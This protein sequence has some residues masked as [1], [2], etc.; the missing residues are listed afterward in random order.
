MACPIVAI[1]A[2]AGGLEAIA[3]LL[4]ASPPDDGMTYV[5]IQHLDPAHKSLLADILEKKTAIPVQTIHDGM[6]V[7]PGRVYVMPQNVSLTLNDSRFRL[8]ARGSGRHHPIDDF[9]LSLAEVRAEAAIGV[10]LSGADADGTLGMQAIKQR[11][12]ITFAQTPESAR[13]GGMPRSAIES[14]CVD[15]VLRPREIAH[16]LTHLV[17]HPYLARPSG[18]PDDASAASEEALLRRIFR[19]LRAVH[20]VD[21]SHYKRSTLRRRIARRMALHKVEELTDYVAILEND[22]EEAAALYQDFLIRVTGFFRDPESFDGLRERV[23]PDVREGRSLKDPIRIWVPGCATGEEVYSI[24]MVLMEYLGE[25]HSAIG[26]QIFATDVSEAAIEKARAALY[27]DVVAQELSA[28]RLKRFFVKEDHRYRV[29]KSLRDLCIFARQDVT[30]DP[31]FSRLDLVSC[32]N[33]LIYLDAAAQRRVMQIFHYALR[34]NGFL[35]LGPSESVGTARDFFELKDK[36]RRIYKRKVLAAGAGLE[37]V[38]TRPPRYDRPQGQLA[39]AEASSFL[40]VDS[41]Q[42]E[43]DLLLLARF[44]PASLLVD[45]ALNILQVRGE[46]GRYLELAS[47]Q[48]SLNLHRVAR[49]ELLVEIVPAIQ[50]ARENGTAAR[51][52]GLS[53]SELR[54]ITIEVIPLQRL[55]TERC[56][57]ILFDDGSRSLLARRSKVSVTAALPESEKDRRLE[58]LEREIGAMRDY[59]QASTEEHEAVKEEL[60]SAHEEVLSANEEFQSTN[61]ELETAKE[62]LQS[63]NE[64]L[65][66]TNDELRNRNRELSVLNTEVHTARETSERA[67]SYAEAIINAVRDPLIVLDGNLKVLRAN[68]AF[69]TNFKVRS[70]DIEGRFLS[71]IDD[72][73]WNVPE[74]IERLREVLTC[75]TIIGNFHVRYNLPNTLLPQTLRVNARKIP[76][77]GERAEL[78]LMAVEDADAEQLREAMQRKDEFLAML[79]HELRNPLT[80]IAHAIHL[81]RHGGA[82]TSPEKAYDLIERQTARLVR[83]VDQLLDVA[84]ISRGHIDLKR[85]TVDLANVV[86]NAADAIQTRLEERQ[87]TL[88][89]MLP[90]GPV[91]VSGDAIRLEQVV[92][93]LLDNAVKYT[94]P[95]GRIELQLRQENAQA[96]L[97]VRDNGVGLV[98]EDL[99]RIFDLFI[100]VNP[101]FARTAG[102]LGIGLTLVRRILALL[103]GTIEARSAGLGHGT[104]FIVRLPIVWPQR[105]PKANSRGDLSS[106]AQPAQ[107]RRV[108]IIDDN[109]DSGDSL[110]LVARS[111]GHEVAVARDGPSALEVAE[112]FQPDCA[113]VDIGLPGMSGY[114]L[115]RRLRD[116]HR[117]L[118]LVA[119][120]GYGRD[121]DRKAAHA[122]GFD[123][124]LVKPADL[125]ELRHLLANVGLESSTPRDS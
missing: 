68:R 26:I 37:F 30:R 5:V 44:A 84:R 78:V 53:V 80:P 27:P 65:T 82:S 24:G 125:D 103:G 2:S 120:T 9:F 29:A 31:P 23:F 57:L 100:Q 90:D 94:E 19:Q 12:G 62:E 73:Q 22:A 38:G 59:L 93:N 66:T 74:L 96:F 107:A 6:A 123:R 101:S 42:R 124:H 14:D 88:A 91:C 119:L 92:A 121:E 115:G 34:P 87:H 11:G 4:A 61:E 41:A 17:R 105:T 63:T 45:E 71:E 111:W 110:A 64:E 113:L 48:P 51:R 117:H 25:E 83:L 8:T 36:R 43:A 33:L 18:P 67:R 109:A 106:S 10:V 58:Q 21:F 79:G 81:L 102:G 72:G 86:Q 98:P 46:T 76:G 114:E 116:A 118:Y 55:S 50:E 108:L 122:A 20:G 40:E 89:V 60:K 39:N 56:Y 70:Q 99:E 47:G 54:D 49:P 3:E 104:E 7:E 32:R 77:D 52:A 95:G 15:F 16:E 85:E 69:Y 1:G 28:E 13:F 112:E 75:N 97:S 35:L